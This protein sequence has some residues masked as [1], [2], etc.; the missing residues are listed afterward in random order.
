MSLMGDWV[1]CAWVTGSVIISGN[2]SFSQRV[3]D[4][5]SILTSQQLGGPPLAYTPTHLPVAQPHPK[6]QP[7]PQV[8]NV[9]TASYSVFVHP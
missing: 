4:T 6:P 2:V 9:N 3:F 8:E 7:P 5:T 1:I